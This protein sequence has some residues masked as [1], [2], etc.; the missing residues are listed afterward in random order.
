MGGHALVYF[1][2]KNIG[3]GQRC[4]K[5]GGNPVVTKINTFAEK[6][7]KS[8]VRDALSYYFLEFPIYQKKVT[9]VIFSVL[10]WP[11]PI[12]WFHHDSQSSDFISLYFEDS[13]P[14]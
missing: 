4:C 10:L 12:A 13:V 7:K 5:L 1:E 11:R 3:K 8:G 14:T 9:V 2:K 6:K